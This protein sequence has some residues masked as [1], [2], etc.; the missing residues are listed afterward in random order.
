MN[1]TTGSSLHAK[2]VQVE[3]EIALDGAAKK[4][5]TLDLDVVTGLI[6]RGVKFDRKFL[7]F[8]QQYAKGND[9]NEYL[10]N[11]LAKKSE[12]TAEDEEEVAKFNNAIKR[13]TKAIDDFQDRR[14]L[15]GHVNVSLLKHL[16]D[17]IVA[18]QSELTVEE[19]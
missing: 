10:Q 4:G 8:I 1:M 16:A 7:S 9:P 15:Y 17:K 3:A 18:L 2:K 5:L 12:L 6:D 11:M 13:G 19:N 14:D